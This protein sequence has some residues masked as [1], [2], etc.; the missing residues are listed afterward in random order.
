MNF[1]QQFLSYI[2]EVVI[3][4]ISYFIWIVRDDYGIGNS[5]RTVSELL[6]ERF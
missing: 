3:E 1:T 6:Q 4:T 5:Y 2:R